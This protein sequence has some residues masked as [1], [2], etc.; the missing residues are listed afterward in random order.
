MSGDTGLRIARLWDEALTQRALDLIGTTQNDAYEAALAI[1]PEDTREWWADLLARN[2]NK[3]EEDEE[4]FICRRAVPAALQKRCCK[5]RRVGNARRGVELRFMPGESVA[6]Q[7]SSPG[8][9][10]ELQSRHTETVINPS[11]EGSLIHACSLEH[12][13]HTMPFSQLDGGGV[14][15]WGV[16]KDRLTGHAGGQ[17]LK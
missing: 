9:L 16:E 17:A 2:P 6:S 8:D 1:L 10:T 11:S 4:P 14:G 5:L 7:P 12:R 15:F 3:L 13:L